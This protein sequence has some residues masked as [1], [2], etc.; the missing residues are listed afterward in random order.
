MKKDKN[1]KQP[2]PRE[3]V[4]TELGSGVFASVNGRPTDEEYLIENKNDRDGTDSEAGSTK[5][6][7][8]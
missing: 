6:T 5:E 3:F 7:G 8:S 4:P 1:Y 2:P